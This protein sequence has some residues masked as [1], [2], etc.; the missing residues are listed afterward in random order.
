MNTLKSVRFINENLDKLLI[1]KRKSIKNL[2]LSCNQFGLKTDF[3]WN[4]LPKNLKVFF[5]KKE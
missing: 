2:T 4:E 3:N 5:D 1:N